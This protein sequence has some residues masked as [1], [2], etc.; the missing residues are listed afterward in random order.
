[1]YLPRFLDVRLE[2]PEMR[3]AVS[4]LFHRLL[5]EKAKLRNGRLITTVSDAARWVLERELLEKQPPLDPEARV[6]LSQAKLRSA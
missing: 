3:Q 4:E 6:R 1:M 5:A 2:T